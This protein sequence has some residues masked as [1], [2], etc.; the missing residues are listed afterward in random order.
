MA[1]QHLA[2]GR[3]VEELPPPAAHALLGSQRVI[4]RDDIVDVQNALQPFA[5][6][7]DGAGAFIA[8]FAR[9]HQ[10]V[11]VLQRPAVILHIGHFQPRG[12]K[13]H[14]HVDDLGQLVQVLAVHHGIDGQRQVRLARPARHLQLFGMA[15]L[16]AA[17][18]VRDARLGTLKTDLDVAQPGILQRRQPVRRQ[19]HPRSDQVG[20]K[21][22]IGGPLHKLHQILAHSRL[23][24][25]K[26]DLQ[27]ADLG[28]FAKDAQ[29]LGGCQF[30]GGGFKLQRVGTIRALQRA[31]V[32]YL[33]Q[34]GQGDAVGGLLLRCI[35]HAGDKLKVGNGRGLLG[36]GLVSGKVSRKP[37]SARSCK[38]ARQS[39]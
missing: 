4:V 25:G 26:M 37:L 11:A 16:E 28:Q 5:R 6:G 36:H 34:H 1:G 39:V 7:I 12:I 14:R 29:P 30:L 27:N 23:A 3:D 20:I 31:F 33:G 24:T 15:V 21:P 22:H 2:G 18:A 13:R 17:H 10:S 8:L 32:G 38:R 9:R 19:H 35:A